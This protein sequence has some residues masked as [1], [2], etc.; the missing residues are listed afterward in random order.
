MAYLNFEFGPGAGVASA[1][2][3][4][5]GL[6][7][8]E[9][10]IVLLSRGDGVRSVQSRRRYDW[11]LNLIYGFNSA[12][13]LADQK[14]EALRRYAVLRRL[15]GDHMAPEEVDQVRAAGFAPSKLANLH[16]MVDPWRAPRQR[17]QILQQSLTILAMGVLGAL[18]FPSISDSVGDELI[19]VLLIGVAFVT[20]LPLLL[21]GDGRR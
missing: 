15:H 19:A 7:P 2:T 8:L 9:R 17:H 13:S 18:L 10:Q 5:A 20:S 21:A 11:V 1:P 14:L 3:P 6:D 16:R 4:T 12:R